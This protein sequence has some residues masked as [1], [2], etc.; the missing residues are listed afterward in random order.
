MPQSGGGRGNEWSVCW[1]T[2]LGG[3]A[4]TPG[5]DTSTGVGSNFAHGRVVQPARIERLDALER[6]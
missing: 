3:D 4:G 1:R 5:S 6:R 2:Q